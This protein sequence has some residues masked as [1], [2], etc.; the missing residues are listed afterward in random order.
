M[1]IEPELAAIGAEMH[2]WATDLFP[3]ARSITGPATLETLE[4]LARLMPGMTIGSIESGTP[5]F[6]WTVPDEWDIRAA[7]I[8]DES[9]RRIVDMKVNN[10]HVLNYST[11]VDE[12]LSLD[13]LDKHLYSLPD[14]PDAIPYVTSYYAR[15]WGFCLSHR[16]RQQLQPGQYRA[17]IDS[18]LKPG[19]LNYGELLIPGREQQEILLSTYVCHPSMANN[20]L[21]GPVVTAALARWLSARKN[22]RYSYRIVF[23]PE[24]IGSI[25]YLSRHHQHMKQVTIAG[26]VLT[27]IGDERTYSFIPSRKGNTYADQAAKHVLKHVFPAYKSYSFLD[28]GSDER[29]YCS[30]GI[31]LPVASVTRSKYGEYPEYHTS[32]DNLTLVTPAGLAG[33]LAVYQR[34]LECIESDCRPRSTVMCE[35]QLGKRGLYPTLSTRGSGKTVKSMMDLIAYADGQT[36]LLDI[37]DLINVPAWELIPI[38]ERLT[39]AGLLAKD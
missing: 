31:D 6:D 12:W 18:E 33:G 8:E 7:Y 4:Y 16:Q 11:P 3:L 2:G 39:D 37:A 25:V 28:R 15:R 23:I 21:S 35:P 34:I 29:Q 13:E 36:S 17:V 30:P 27:C 22:L 26:Y 19:L 9:G 5:A 32:L 1:N 24:T 14:Q 10:L 20:E 38:V